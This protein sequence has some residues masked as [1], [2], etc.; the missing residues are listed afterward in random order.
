MG[1]S[2]GRICREILADM[3]RRA[4]RSLKERSSM[5]DRELNSSNRLH[6][7]SRV[8]AIVQKHVSTLRAFE[9]IVSPGGIVT[10]SGTVTS[11]HD[12]I[13]VEQK[14]RAFQEVQEVVNNIEVI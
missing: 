2:I 11:E 14:V 9:V 10:I 4:P 1:V 13:A 5:T 12:K 3:I 6:L 7:E 8:K